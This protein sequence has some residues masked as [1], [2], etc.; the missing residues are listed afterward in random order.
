ML[1]EHHFWKKRGEGEG[2]AGRERKRERLLLFSLAQRI[3]E[4]SIKL[5]FENSDCLISSFHSLHLHSFS[6]SFSLPHLSHTD[7]SIGIS[8][9]S[10]IY[11]YLHIFLT[12]YLSI[13]TRMC[14]DIYKCV[15]IPCMYR[16]R[17][18]WI[19]YSQKSYFL[20]ISLILCPLT[21]NFLYR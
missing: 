21:A 10:S 13:Y 6:L 12:I 8:I 11:L 17:C 7:I 4:I 9:L 16:H 18:V 3:T 20:L 1:C 2:K 5:H 14:T 15:Y 19:S